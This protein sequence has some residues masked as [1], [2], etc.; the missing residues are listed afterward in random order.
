[1]NEIEEEIRKG[2]GQAINTDSLADKV[3]QQSREILHVSLVPVFFRRWF[4]LSFFRSFR[5]PNFYGPTFEND[6]L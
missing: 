4:S 6:H 3:A 1:M 5:F 2:K